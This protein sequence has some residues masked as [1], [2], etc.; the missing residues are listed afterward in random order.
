MPLL[1]A[2]FHKQSQAAE[3]LSPDI[4]LLQ[5]RFLQLLTL[6]DTAQALIIL[7]ILKSLKM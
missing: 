3:T 4:L 1:I 7:N 5:K 2:S 6:A